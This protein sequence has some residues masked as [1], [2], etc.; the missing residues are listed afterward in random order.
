MIWIFR[1]VGGLGVGV[2]VWRKHGSGTQEQKPKPWEG[3]E[4]DASKEGRKLGWLENNEMRERVVHGEIG[5]VGR[6]K[7]LEPADPS[8]FLLI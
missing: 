8:I 5:E 7:N 1:R 2:G 4:L 6:K 3:N